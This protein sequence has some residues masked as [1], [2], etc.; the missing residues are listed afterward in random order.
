MRKT[1][2]DRDV[3]APGGAGRG[4]RGAADDAPSGRGVTEGAA[5]GGVTEGAASGGVADGAALV[6][7]LELGAAQTGRGLAVYPLF[8]KT[9]GGPWYVTLAE[10]I[11]NGQARISEVDEGG[12]V[13]NLSVV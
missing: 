1:R 4:T 10:A 3:R 2:D 9:E 7:L 8:A 5:S 11:A 6:E 13:P 12:S